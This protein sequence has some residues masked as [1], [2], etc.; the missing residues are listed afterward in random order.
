MKKHF[1]EIAHDNMKKNNQSY[2]WTPGSTSWRNFVG[3]SVPESSIR[4]AKRQGYLGGSG[5][6]QLTSL[7]YQSF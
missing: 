2:L 4:R 3:D 5:I 7:G 6:P 1:L